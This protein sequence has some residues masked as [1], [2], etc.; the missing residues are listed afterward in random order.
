M[1]FDMYQICKDSIRRLHEDIESNK[2][3][4]NEVIEFVKGTL[5]K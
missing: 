2:K 5:N 3:K 1:V 4:V